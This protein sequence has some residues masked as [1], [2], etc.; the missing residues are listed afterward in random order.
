MNSVG[1]MIIQLKWNSI[2]ILDLFTKTSQENQ[3][4]F[5]NL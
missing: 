2:N 3:M 4:K 5:S 1:I